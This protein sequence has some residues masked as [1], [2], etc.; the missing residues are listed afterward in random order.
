MMIQ[1]INM[2]N[3]K[4]YLGCYYSCS[5][6]DIVRKIEI[7]DC[8]ITNQ[9]K[10]TPTQNNITEYSIEYKR[11]FIEYIENIYGPNKEAKIDFKTNVKEIKNAINLRMTK[12]IDGINLRSEMGFNTN[13]RIVIPKMELYKNL[14]DYMANSFTEESRYIRKY[15]SEMYK[16]LLQPIVLNHNSEEVIVACTISVYD[17]N[18]MMIDFDIPLIDINFKDLLNY[19]WNDPNSVL[20]QLNCILPNSIV[21]F[22]ADEKYKYC[23]DKKYTILE[24]IKIYGDY[25]INKL[26]IVID[27]SSLVEYKHY[28]ITKFDNQPK[29]GWSTSDDIKRDLYWLIHS[30]SNGLDFSKNIYSSFFEN[31]HEIYKFARMYTSSNPTSMIV[32]TSEEV[33]VGNSLL[34]DYDKLVMSNMYVEPIIKIIVTKKVLL[35][36]IWNVGSKVNSSDVIQKEEQIFHYHDRINRMTYN[37]YGTV[38]RAVEFIEKNMVDYLNFSQIDRIME[39]YRTLSTI[40]MQNSYNKVSKNIT[41]YGI[42]ITIFL[43][44]Q[45]LSE[46]LK[47]VDNLLCTHLANYSPLF[48]IAIIV[49]LMVIIYFTNKRQNN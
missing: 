30:P 39:T 35:T 11:S 3:H 38:K 22:G 20:N 46:I 14:L 41:I 9:E 15:K 29:S 5:F 12:N 40:K 27:D 28:N 23:F 13:I 26:K 16:G 34:N 24:A 37:S 47:S 2:M 31:Y 4:R 44:Y 18:V 17:N 6:V 8:V 21:D 32:F 45:P 33:K 1:K 19:E 43:G 42:I 48:L 7:L 36:K 49:I 10:K 25:I